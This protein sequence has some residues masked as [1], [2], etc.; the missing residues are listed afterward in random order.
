MPSTSHRTRLLELLVE[1]SLILGEFT[2]A[3]GARSSW[4]IDCRRT[5]MSA[6]GQFLIGKVA[7][8]AIRERKLDPA[9]VGGLTMGADPISYAIAHASWQAGRP[10][11]A[12]SIRKAAKSHGAGRR[13]EGAL[14]PGDPVIVIEDAMTSGASALEAVSALEA[15]NHPI[16][17]VLTLVDREAGGSD[18]IR[19]S[20]RPLIALFTAAELLQVSDG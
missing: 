13:I 14:T 19:S 9:A 12:F 11:E 16:L 3:S 10:I 8:E 6:E 20:G 5:T 2:L 7:L 15:E 18:L 4:Y 1:R 17:A